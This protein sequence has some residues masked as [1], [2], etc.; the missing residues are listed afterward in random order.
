MGKKPLT[1]DFLTKAF[2]YDHLYGI[3]N[4]AQIEDFH[5]SVLRLRL[6]RVLYEKNSRKGSWETG[7]R[8]EKAKRK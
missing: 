4:E 6:I 5:S 7:R 1:N 8:K 2:L 3:M